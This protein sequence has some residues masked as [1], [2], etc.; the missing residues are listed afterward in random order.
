MR[1]A[2]L[3]TVSHRILHMPPSNH[4]CIVWVLFRNQCDEEEWQASLLENIYY[5]LVA[6]NNN[7]FSSIGNWSFEPQLKSW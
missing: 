2:R 6:I 4:A 3:L 1:T 5:I 7:N